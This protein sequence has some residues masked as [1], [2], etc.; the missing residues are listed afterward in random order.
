M[1]LYDFAGLA[2]GLGGAALFV[3]GVLVAL[4]AGLRLA[5]VARRPGKGRIARGIAAGGAV[6]A[7]AGAA[8]FWL[9]ELAP[10]RRSVDHLTA[11]LAGLA[12]VL[13]VLAGWRV[14]R[15]RPASPAVR[16]DAGP[17]AGS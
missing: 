16:D 2:G 15:R 6:I 5:T 11:P 9:A 12:L 4:L 10:F 3:G 17:V 13:G 7:A 14:A 8:L 1:S